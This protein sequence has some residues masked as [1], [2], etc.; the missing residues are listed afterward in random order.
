VVLHVHD[1][2]VIESDRPEDV[3]SE[4]KRVMTTCP[5]WAEGLPLAAEVK[6]MGRYGK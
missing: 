2:I 3:A 1:E 6:I 4:L 5:S